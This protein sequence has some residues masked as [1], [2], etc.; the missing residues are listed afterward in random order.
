MGSKSDPNQ[1]KAIVHGVLNELM[2]LNDP[3]LLFWIVD[4]RLGLFQNIN[5]KVSPY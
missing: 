1:S 5:L 3:I 2:R 4:Y